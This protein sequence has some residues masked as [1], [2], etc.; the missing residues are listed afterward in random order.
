MQQN[1]QARPEN[2]QEF[3][4]AVNAKLHNQQTH[5]ANPVTETDQVVLHID[6]DEREKQQTAE[7]RKREAKQKTARDDLK[8]VEEN[9]QADGHID[10]VV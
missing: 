1:A 10:I 8:S 4:K 5:T 7:D 2:A 6:E 3:E 9:D